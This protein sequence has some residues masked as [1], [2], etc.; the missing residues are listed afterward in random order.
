[1]KN[2]EAK[3]ATPF[4]LQEEAKG[5]AFKTNQIGNEFKLFCPSIQLELLKNSS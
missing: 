5:K 2:L 1:M 4:R 3:T